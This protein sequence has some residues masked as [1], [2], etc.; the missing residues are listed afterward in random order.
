MDEIRVCSLCAGKLELN[1]LIGFYECVSCGK[2]YTV[3]EAETPL[4]LSTVSRLIQDHKYDEAQ[5]NIRVLLQN[6]PDNA[7]LQL[8]SFLARRRFSSTA[9][10]LSV[11]A[12]NEDQLMQMKDDPIWRTIRQDSSGQCS[13]LAGLVNEYFD[14]QV[15]RRSL[16]RQFGSDIKSREILEHPA[17]NEKRL[18]TMPQFL[19]F[20][21][22][23]LFWG[24]IVIPASLKIASDHHG[25]VE[26]WSRTQG[27][28]RRLADEDTFIFYV[29]AIIVA[30][31]LLTTFL[32]PVIRRR[33]RK[34]QLRNGKIRFLRN[35]TAVRISS[36]NQDR[37]E[38]LPP[39]AAAVKKYE[40]LD[41]RCKKILEAIRHEE[42]HLLDKA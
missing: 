24:A 22:S 3:E 20:L 40:E 6:D 10:F 25:F 21:L 12:D 8:Y 18:R 17:P 4:S 30:L 2:L 35:G 41:S 26:D 5:E 39:N 33:I 42:S 14:A 38:Y 32:V 9:Q 15:E 28:Y 36:K 1:T 29:S 37:T 27:Y 31:T 7:R 19:V 11:S 23:L 13:K 34:K 16:R